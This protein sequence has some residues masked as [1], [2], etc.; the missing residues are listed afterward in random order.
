V[1]LVRSLEAAAGSGSL[2][3]VTPGD[4]ELRALRAARAVLDSYELPCE[5][6]SVMAGGSN[7][8]VHLRPTPV[9]A[10]V[11]TATAV[12]HDD[13][14]LWLA[15]EVAVGT[16]LGERGLAV[17]PTPLLPPGPH[18]RDGLWI[19][20]WNYVPHDAFNAS[21][22]A[23]QLGHSLRRLH[24]AL[25]EFTGELEPLLGIQRGLERFLD[26]LQPTP[27][28]SATD[29]RS[30]RASLHELIPRVFD[31]SEPAQALHGDMG[32]GNVL[33]TDDGPLWNDLEDVCTGP[34]AWDVAGLVTSARARGQSEAFVEELLHAYG[35]P[36]VDDLADFITA[37]ELYV[38]IWQ[39]YVAQHRP[40]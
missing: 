34:V 23:S 3:G 24:E 15:R 27:S 22:G 12:L 11:M 20:L 4:V 18:Q 5:D 6:A 33:L 13:P 31:S 40:L 37:H 14:E 21:P 19:T 10:R 35:G 29:I 39:S 7:V 16:F 9:V 26:E 32:I 30:L 8:L 2:C 28:L 17:S 36:H 38:T 1:T 25:A